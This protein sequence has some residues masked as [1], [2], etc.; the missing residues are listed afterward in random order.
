MCGGSPGICMPIG[1]MCGCGGIPGN[2]MRGMRI[3]CCGGMPGI[4]L[5]TF[6]TIGG[7]KCGGR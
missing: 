5:A 1:S 4:I 3:C 7:C 6:E 2:G